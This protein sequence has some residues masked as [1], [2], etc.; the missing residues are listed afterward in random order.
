MKL[1]LSVVLLALTTASG[2]DVPPGNTLRQRVDGADIVIVG[3]LTRSGLASAGLELG[4]PRVPPGLA[5]FPC[6]IDLKVEAILKGSLGAGVRAVTVLSYLRRADCKVQLMGRD[7]PYGH[8][9][10]WFLRRQGP[11]LR[12]SEDDRGAMIWLSSFPPGTSERIRRF[13]DPRLAVAYLLLAPD[14]G[15]PAANYSEDVSWVARDVD[16]MVGFADFWK[17]LET[18][19]V[20][21][22]ARAKAH[23]C[24]LA[25]R[26]GACL[27]CAHAAIEHRVESSSAADDVHSLL[28]PGQFEFFEQQ[29]LREMA[30]DSVARAR[31]TAAKAKL[32]EDDLFWCACT[33]SRELRARARGLLHT[34]FGVD[35]RAIACVPCAN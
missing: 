27:A 3:S 21:S 26:S 34:L 32:L 24:L 23:V 22:P 5:A 11:L 17:I 2:F 8:S 6:T 29:M 33:S 28:R 30:P 10:V 31:Q 15:V 20:Q 16:E 7:V 25:S 9:L 4:T 19:Y 14:I 35:P 12:T 18:I 1:Y 13:T